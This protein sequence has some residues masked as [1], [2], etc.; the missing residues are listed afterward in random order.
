MR[1]LSLSFAFLLM[2]SLA[3]LA[4]SAD[5]DDTI[6]NR[7]ANKD[8]KET[9]QF[10]K[11]IDPM[12]GKLGCNGRACHG[13]FQGQGDFRLSLFGYD[14]KMDHDGLSERLDT[15][16]PATSYVLQ[17]ATLE[18]PHKGGKRFDKS[19]WEY[20]VFLNWIKGGAKGVD[21]QTPDLVKLDVTPKEMVFKK[22][23]Q[24]VQM[25]AV[26]EWSDGTFED[27]TPLCRYQVNNEQVAEISKTGLLTSNEPGDS[28]VVVFYDAAVVP[29][30]IMQPVSNKIGPKYP[31]P[32]TPTRIDQLVVTKLRKMGIMQSDTCAD[33]DFLRR[34]SLDMTGSLPTPTEVKQFVADKR[35]NKRSKKIDELLSRPSYAAWWATKI[36]D[37]TGNSD[38]QLNNVVPRGAARTASQDWYEWVH[39]RVEDNVPYDQLAEGFVLA[40]SRN[41]GE[42]YQDYCKEMSKLYRKSNRDGS[43]ADRETMPHYWSR[44]NFQQP[45]DRAIG[46][47]YTFL[48]IRIQCAQ[49]HKHPFDRWT[50]DD[51]KQFTAFFKATDG[52]TSS[53]APE[54]RK[55]YT[56]MLKKFDTDGLKGNDLRKKMSEFMNEGKIV[57]FGEVCAT[58]PRVTVD[59]KRTKKTKGKKQG[60]Q[61]APKITG[62]L[63]GAEVVDLKQHKDV[64]TPLMKWLRAPGNDLFAKAFVNRVWAGYFNVGIVNPPDD[65]S[66]ANPPSNQQLLDYLAQGFVENNYDMKWLHREI[67]NSRTYQLSWQ[68]ND[69][70]KLDETN[71]SRAVPRRL[72]AEV[73]Y[74]SLAQA[75]SSD[76]RFAEIQTSLD[77]RA[78]AIHG[79]SQQGRTRGVD[80]DVLY[81]MRVFGRSV[82]ESNCDCDRTSESSL[83]QTVFLRNDNQTLSMLDDKN[84]W[85]A[86][87]ATDAGARFVPQVAVASND[88]RK[89]KAD[90]IRKTN[91]KRQYD[92]TKK[93]VDN[94]RKQIAAAKK[95]G[96]EKQISALE[97]RKKTFDKRLAQ[98]SRQLKG[99]VTA[100]TQNVAKVALNNKDVIEQAY[101]RTLSRLPDDKETQIAMSFLDEAKGDTI[102][103]ARGLLWAL[104]NTKEFVVN[105]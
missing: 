38:D 22:E 55:T 99:N 21:K 86:Q 5:I 44:R 87:L 67:C 25:K 59:R 24:K 54:N 53:A 97:K 72:P 12:L 26:A 52:R 8:V 48:G 49:C 36:C 30:P 93:Q 42:S 4:V 27:V 91:L 65:H 31:K 29:I 51:F 74:D 94:M 82:R 7:F 105:H 95:S 71:F 68:S 56:A 58:V 39:K 19:S 96:K 13:S 88:A 102:N 32:A 43:Y 83:L 34:V 23:G 37:F 77:G 66:L 104:I 15:D 16:D 63:L 57:P 78:I 10:R 33:T 90:K 98:L 89:K 41:D 92:A 9:P 3:T 45:E 84:G 2:P 11:H 69:T 20:H 81:A 100:D 1:I 64:R 46:F 18:E 17:K 73:V 80:R 47:A 79:A 14:F 35:S 50:Q 85:L 61:P 60:K 70:N 76:K 6:E 28:H 75:T 40:K 103:G 101:L 62:K